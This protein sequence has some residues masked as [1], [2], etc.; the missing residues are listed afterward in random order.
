MFSQRWRLA[1]RRFIVS[2]R[3]DHMI[4]CA[5]RSYIDA[6]CYAKA[7][8][9]GAAD[10]QVTQAGTFQAAATLITLRELR[11]QRFSDNL[12]RVMH[13]VPAPG[14]AVV[15]FRTEPGPALVWSG[16]QMLPTSIFWH[17]YDSC[18]FQRSSGSASWGTMSLPE[19]IM[20]GK[21]AMLAGRDLTTQRRPMTM[22][23]K[24]AAMAKLQRL[25]ASFGILAATAPEFVAVPEAVRGFEQALVGALADCLES[26]DPCN[27]TIGQRHHAGVM[28]RFRRV[29]AANDERAL[30]MADISAAIGVS[31]RTLRSCCREYLGMG[32]KQYLT[33]R[34]LHLVRRA[35]IRA[36]PDTLTVT[37]AATHYGFWE[38]GQFSAKYKLLFGEMPSQ[39]LRRDGGD[40]GHTEDSTPRPLAL[41]S[42]MHP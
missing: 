13:A 30:Y 32:P 21:V 34:R 1:L 5:V 15:S 10:L 42:S 39:T 35:L 40:V 31:G 9:D 27:E 37:A 28:R 8:P 3:E 16:Q 36:A 6:D 29:V 7:M 12:P 23:P 17:G 4:S 18:S 19:E 20:G 14:R 24:P 26:G 25:H 41:R 38:L 2:R 11:V 22:V 33:L